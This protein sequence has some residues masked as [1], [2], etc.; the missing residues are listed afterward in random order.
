MA[1]E[2]RKYQ[3][4]GQMWLLVGQTQ[5]GKSWFVRDMLYRMRHVFPFGWIFTH[6]KHNNFWRQ[7]F[8][9]HLIFP[10][11]DDDV[12]RAIMRLQ[13]GRKGHQG[14]NRNVFILLDDVASEALRY[15]NT[16]RELAMEGRHYNITTIMTTQHFTK[17]TTEIRANAWWAV[18][19]T[20]RHEPTLDYMASEWMGTDFVDKYHVRAFIEKNTQ[21]HQA[22]VIHRHPYL[23]APERYWVHK[24]ANLDDTTFA[25][26][27]DRAW[28]G[29]RA[30]MA[31]RQRRDFPLPKDYSMSYLQQ[32]FQKSRIRFDDL[33][34]HRRNMEDPF[35]VIDD[36]P[37]ERQPPP[38][39]PPPGAPGGPPPPGG[40]PPPDG[41]DPA[42]SETM[43]RIAERGM[44]RDYAMQRDQYGRTQ[45]V[46]NLQTAAPLWAR[47][48][49]LAQ[50]QGAGTNWLR[51]ALNP[52]PGDAAERVPPDERLPFSGPAT[53]ESPDET[54]ERRARARSTPAQLIYR[55]G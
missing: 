38:A 43:R 34:R 45:W 48:D 15:Q 39:P 32:Q 53:P 14:M 4:I 42:A 26:L 2:E 23:S 55:G 31:E 54:D 37:T 12:V 46:R 7:Y 35:R 30:Q 51:R 28:E 29:P 19:F 25:M 11:Y 36:I 1:D 10:R 16:L 52:P 24:A 13:R 49:P 9:N 6:T 27:N 50:Q 33:V 22:V 18:I 40:G 47:Q 3:V 21:D 44:I 20:T 5:T 8:P 41:G 17:A